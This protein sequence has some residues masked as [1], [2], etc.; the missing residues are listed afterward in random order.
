[1]FKMMTVVYEYKKDYTKNS[2]KR[3]YLDLRFDIA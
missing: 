3:Y 2:H 1:M